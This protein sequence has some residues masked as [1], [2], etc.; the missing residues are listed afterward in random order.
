MSDPRN[1]SIVWFR[2]DLR[3]ADNPVLSA[4]L[5]CGSRVLPVFVLDEHAAGLWAP[6]GAQRWW[7]HHSLAAL[8]HDL[9]QRGAGLVLRRGSADEIIPELAKAV[10]AGTVHAMR[11]I[12]PW[13]RR[14]EQRVSRAVEAD[15]VRLILHQSATLF[16]PDSVRTHTGTPYRIYTHFARA[17]RNLSPPGNPKPTPG[18]I[19]AIDICRSDELADWHLLPTNPDWA[20]GLRENWQPGETGAMRRLKNFLTE[21][22]NCYDKDRD[23]PDRDGTTKLSP[24]LHWGE[25]SV[26]TVWHAAQHDGSLSRAREKLLGELLWREFAANLLWHNPHLPDHCLRPE[27]QHMPWRHDSAALHAWRRGRTGVPIVDAGMRQLWHT[28][29][30]H[31]RVRMVVASFLTKHLLLPWQDGEAWFWDTLVDTDLANNST[32][33]QWVA[34]CGADAAPFFRVFNPVLQGQKFDPEAAYVRAWVPELR[35]LGAKQ[36]HAP[37]QAPPLVLKAAGVELGRS[38]PYPIVDLVAGRRR[39]LAALRSLQQSP[40]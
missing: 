29:W 13:A 24:H 38:Y 10:G 15:G 14:Q 22:V 12:E 33:W 26:A 30:M 31:N 11:C 6:G 3:L 18:R 32:N 1:C 39:A 5:R 36:I 2:Q 37:W 34:G 35:R 25:I 20:G 4:A 23:W 7:L 21:R 16:D 9:R 19:P 8:S 17:Y 27:F 40:A 28:G